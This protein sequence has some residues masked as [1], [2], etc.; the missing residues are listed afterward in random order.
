MTK[1]RKFQTKEIQTISIE[2]YL[3]RVSRFAGSEYGRI[4]REQFRD[5]EGFSELGM[6]ASPTPDELEQLRRAVAIMTPD[7]KQNA[8]DLT[9]EQ[10][11]K[12]AADAKVDAGLFAIFLNGYALHHRKHR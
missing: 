2:Q 5:N 6:L 10:I 4:V 8:A 1:K 3:E 7:E 11:H 9:D 12:I